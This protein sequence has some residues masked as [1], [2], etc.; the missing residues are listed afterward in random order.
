[1]SPW[2]M[3]RGA[4]PG[5]VDHLWTVPTTI[6]TRQFSSGKAGGPTVRDRERTNDCRQHAFECAV[7]ETGE[8]EQRIGVVTA[9]VISGETGG[10]AA[11]FAGCW[12]LAAL[13]P[14]TARLSG[15]AITQAR[16]VT[17]AQRLQRRADASAVRFRHGHGAACRADRYLSAARKFA[18]RAHRLRR[19]VS[20]AG[21][22][23]ALLGFKRLWRKYRA[24]RDAVCRSH[25]RRLRLDL[26]PMA[27]AFVDVQR[28]AADGYS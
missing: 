15:R 18:S 5:S 21:D 23:E 27:Q 4:R 12:A 6:K 7:A 25:D 13:E 2:S 22:R 20:S 1:M 19:T 3:R 11:V 28:L 24:S 14:A 26:E 17:A 9:A 10:Q 8:I 16:T